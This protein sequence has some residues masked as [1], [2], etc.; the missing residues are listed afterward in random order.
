[1]HRALLLAIL[2][3]LG[4]RA[5]AQPVLSFE[6]RRLDAT[7]VRGEIALGAQ[8]A[9][10]W[11][12][13]SGETPSTR[14][15]ILRGDVSV[16]LATTAFQADRV[17]IWIQQLDGPEPR[18]QL[19]CYAEGVDTPSAAG[20]ISIAAESIAIEGVLAGSPPVTL[21]VDQLAQERTEDIFTLR[22]EQAFNE[23][24][25]ADRP[26]RDAA[27]W[28]PADIPLDQPPPP[29]A[30]GRTILSSSGAF[31]V[32]SGTI[33]YRAEGDDRA[34]LL[35][36][37]V[38]I[39]YRDDDRS[40]LLSAQRAAVFLT[41]GSSS[42]GS[43]LTSVPAGDIQGVYLEGNVVATSDGYTVRGRRAYYDVTQERALLLDAVFSQYNRRRGTP[44][45]VR[46]RAVHQDAPGLFRAENARVSN[47]AFF[48]PQ[49]TLGASSVT[50]TLPDEQAEPGQPG[51]STYADARNLTLRARGVPVAYFPLYRGDP[52]R[53]PLENIAF[54]NDS[55]NGGIVRT[56]WDLL[57]LLG[58]NRPK[59]R[60]SAIADL[61]T[62]RG[63]AL[64]TITGW[65]TSNG[66]G[67]LFA[68]HLFDD[69]GTDDL[70][71]GADIDRFGDE[72]T[73]LLAEHRAQLTEQ[74]SIF[75]EAAY[76]SD[77]TFVDAEFEE[78]A[79]ERREFR[80]GATLVR[81]DDNT[82]GSIEA[83]G[84]VNDF[85]V[86]QHILT[87]DAYQVE[88]LPEGS[89]SRAADDVLAGIAPGLLTS[90]FDASLGVNRLRFTDRTPAE[91]GFLGSRAQSAFGVN[92]NT[93][94]AANLRARGLNESAV[95]RLDAR[96]ELSLQLATGPVEV[97]PFAVG[98]LTAYDQTFVGFNN[99]E[100]E[101]HRLFGAVGVTAST[102]FQRTN[103]TARSNLFDVHRLR[104]IIEPNAT[105][106]TAGTS[107]DR[108]E[109]PVYDD[110][111]EALAEGTVLRVGIDQTLQTK[112]G[113]PGRWENVDLLKLRLEYTDAS[114][115]ASRTSPIPRFNEPRPENSNPGEALSA[116][117]T[118]QA[119]D[120]VA[121]NSS[122]VHN[123][124]TNQNAAVS[125]GVTL[126][127]S[128]N[129]TSTVELRSLPAVDA[130][131]FAGATRYKLTEKYS[132]S[133][134]ATYDSDE[135]TIQGVNSRFL[136]RFQAA[137]VGM[138][139]SYNNIRGTTSLLFEV[140]PLGARGGASFSRNQDPL[141]GNRAGLGR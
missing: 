18:A 24:W 13:V 94:L 69:T 123:M 3:L 115:E 73:L 46:A 96:E 129:T 26:P 126:N 28:N 130:L 2:V 125:S 81:R 11:T 76:I 140:R 62:G 95:T 38:V 100:T 23:R 71:T 135:G 47:T 82:Q 21:S 17:A 105:I 65:Q 85:A 44:L 36:G 112:R 52:E 14:R 89:Y 132:A 72:R 103:N 80:T 88:K 78:L 7:P 138:G 20:T 139:V 114:G 97:T 119:S 109:L 120:A 10:A 49:L 37:G 42:Q 93:N 31:S 45:Y 57:A 35:T 60:V 59:L 56:R 70:S 1:M 25:S 34:A 15:L 29:T 118:W 128:P 98:R 58:I 79:R 9:A 87:T 8:R 134:S 4:V 83:S 74:W 67:E 54:E 107:I 63:P 6:H 66:D 51:A 131:I 19:F 77:A 40:L 136:R 102:S 117:G 68:Y 22:A 124:Q 12:F 16:K 110:S 43:T 30:R 39:E 116:E 92:Q 122:I 90:S 33:T 84:V 99:T 137:D 121:F 50:I 104:H 113:G 32:S 5:G 106:Y 91:L 133:A 55:E 111:V 75:L 108:E 141:Q 53:F 86:N 61:H 41:P 101:R 64:G 127:H 48:K 27:R